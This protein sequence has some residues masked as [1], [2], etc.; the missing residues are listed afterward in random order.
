MAHTVR[1][2]KSRSVTHSLE[3]IANYHSDQGEVWNGIDEL[4]AKA[5]CHSPTSA[6][7]D[8]FQAHDNE[9]R[10]CEDSLQ[11]VP[12]QLGL[13]VFIEGSPVG[14]DL[15]SLSGAYARLHPKLIRSYTLESLIE[16]R[17][18]QS[19]S[20]DM[21]D[22]GRAFMKRIILCTEDRF[23]SAGCGQDCRYRSPGLAGSALLHENEP[24]HAAWFGLN[25]T[26]QAP[27]RSM[28][29]WRRRRRNSGGTDAV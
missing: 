16:S 10:R 8:V 12:G 14:L 11:C 23:P 27:Q 7:K 2:M 4:Q 3:E 29:S 26:D 15:V 21:V 20:V 1:A 28:A 6:M 24:L 22:R 9:L 25:A 18:E 17:D 13:L 19:P 5:A